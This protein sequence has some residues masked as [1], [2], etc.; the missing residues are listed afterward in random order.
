[1]ANSE[2]PNLYLSGHLAAWF[3][4]ISVGMIT[5]VAFEATAV[6]TAMPFVVDELHGNHLYALASGIP[7]ATQLI[8]TG[9]AGPWVDAKGPRQVLYGGIALFSIGLIVAALAPGIILLV[10]GRAIQGLGGGLLVVPLYV[11]V[12]AY[13][14]PHKQGAF[15]AAFAIAW[16]LP[17]LVG[18]LI[19]GFFV[20]YIHWRWVFGAT[21]L[22]LF[23]LAPLVWPKFNQFPPLHANKPLRMKKRFVFATLASGVLIGALQMIS[24]VKPQ[25]FNGIVIAMA[26]VVSILLF[27]FIQRLVPKGTFLARRGVPATIALRGLLNGTFI[28]TE[29]FLTFMMKNVHGWKPTQAGL[30]MT[31]SG[32]TWAIGSW[33]QGRL[34]GQKTMGLFAII[35]P[36]GQLIGT[37][38]TLLSLVHGFGGWWVLVG[39]CIAG[40]STGLIYPATAVNALAHTRPEK[41]GQISSS[42]QVA[43]TFGSS[44]LIAYG[45]IV[46]ALTFGLGHLAFACTI[47]TLCILV[48]VALWVG[49]RIFP[50]ED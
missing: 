9:L 7:L 8:T 34:P 24:G 47:G 35:G 40:F 15:F 46:Y 39:W 13:V 31:A 18:P 49:T 38:V 2:G 32:V 21:P 16:V 12:G 45:G 26:V 25:N 33:V 20:D 11:M 27:I 4:I 43:D 22:A 50:E 48:V 1:M 3:K 30:V 37:G 6:G 42:L 41:H 19:A 23:L 44:S 14:L 29:T 17:S 5:L 10:L 28:A 36:I